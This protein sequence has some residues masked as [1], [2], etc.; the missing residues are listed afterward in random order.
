VNK[1]RIT[2]LFCINKEKPIAM[3]YGK[4]YL[5]KQLNQ[6]KQEKDENG[7]QL[8]EI[9]I[10]IGVNLLAKVIDFSNSGSPIQ[11]TTFFEDNYSF[12]NN[13]NIFHPPQT[14]A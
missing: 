7:F 8:N 2:E 1:E 5:K 10:F 13:T 3:C 6:T 14:F 9:P 11:H 12:Q 4:C